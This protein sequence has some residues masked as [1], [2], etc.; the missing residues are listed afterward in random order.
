MFTGKNFIEKKDSMQDLNLLRGMTALAGDC[1]HNYG[2]TVGPSWPRNLHLMFVPLMFLFLETGLLF[3]AQVI[4]LRIKHTHPSQFDLFLLSLVKAATL[5][6]CERSSLNTSVSALV[7]KWIASSLF[8]FKR[9]LPSTSV[10]L[11]EFSSLRIKG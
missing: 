10:N 5:S 7:L 4:T 8:V 11:L 9:A 2:V 6:T 1:D 3:L